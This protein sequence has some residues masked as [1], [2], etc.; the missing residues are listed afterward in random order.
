M[1]AGRAVT[2]STLEWPGPR[3]HSS[4]AEQELDGKRQRPGT[5]AG[6]RIVV[7]EVGVLRVKRVKRVSAAGFNVAH[8]RVGQFRPQQ[9]LVFQAVVGAGVQVPGQDSIRE[10]G[11]LTRVVER[12][13]RIVSLSIARCVL[14]IGG[15][16]HP[17]HLDERGTQPKAQVGRKSRGT[18]PE[19]RSMH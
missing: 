5:R 18:H 9:Y 4:A 16:M 19:N 2:D 12:Q 17:G 6:E 8:H 3:W 13:G 1:K 10:I 15:E 11:V 7:G 14:V